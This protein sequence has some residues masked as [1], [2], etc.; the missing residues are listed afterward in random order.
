MGVFC[1]MD[2]EMLAQV[3]KCLN[4]KLDELGI[5]GEIA[6]YGGAVMCL[7]LNARGS[8]HDID[9]IFHPK[10]DVAHA[11]RLVGEELGLPE[12]WLNDGVKGF[13]SANEDLVFFD[14]QSNLHIYVASAQYMLAM[15]LLSCRLDNQSEI[16]DIRFLLRY[17]NV[18]SV[19]QAETIIY[20]YYPKNRVLPKT[21][22]FLMEEIG[23]G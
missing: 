6:I 9:A 21:F 19:S 11:A 1:E 18:S 16:S 17:C 4:A 3:L 7:A 5:T 14:Q 15:K 22:Y 12:D 13:V 10:T 2:R 8:T 20:K 23:V